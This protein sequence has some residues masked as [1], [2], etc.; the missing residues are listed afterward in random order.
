MPGS[1]WVENVKAV[2]MLVFEH[3]MLREIYEQPEALRNTIA[4][5]VHGNTLDTIV[6]E[7][8]ASWSNAA[9]EI[10]IAASGSSR[11]SGLYGEI[12]LEDL[13]GLA[14]DVE[15]A[16]EYSCRG[17]SDPRRPS[18]LVLSQSGE[19]SDTLAALTEARNKK[20]KTLA[21]TNQPSSTMAHTA[22][23]SMPLAAGQEKAIPA[24]KSFTCQ[25]A[26][27][28]LLALYESVRL[29]SIDTNTR[30]RLIEELEAVPAMIQSA[31]D[32]WHLQMSSLAGMYKNASTFLYLGRGIHY[33][34]AR[35]G[36]L[37]LKEASYVHAE[38]YPAGELK[39][40]PNALVSERVP[41]VVMATVDR[42]LEASVVRYEKTLELL[43]YV[44]AEGAKVIALANSDD[45][46]IADLVGNVI[47]V[48]RT[49][50]YLLPILE[51]IPLQLFAY[52]MAL[53]RGVD[54]DRPRNLS[55]AV[56]ERAPVN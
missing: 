46:Q 26:V 5:Y 16:S 41:L 49:S 54:V 42:S 12:L 40:G 11:H 22:D 14:V 6:A 30:G 1:R 39:H 44:K 20:Q 21:I 48:E 19:T 36:A 27:L 43:R 45:E 25:L 56:I 51:V 55:K 2:T 47:R 8:L 29:Q 23:V 33:A 28:Y 3:E 32:G 50:E 7:R 15:Y 31:L 9:G 34:I 37:K 53:E 17:G 18:V 13:C 4:L 10:L 52:F 38:G 35:E 24:T